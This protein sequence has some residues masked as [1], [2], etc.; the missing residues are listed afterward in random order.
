VFNLGGTSSSWLSQKQVW[1]WLYA[2][3]W[4]VIWHHHQFETM[5]HFWSLA[6]EEHFYLVW[7]WVI[8][9]SS[10]KT[11]IRICIACFC[12]SV[13]SR[14]LLVMWGVSKES[15]WHLDTSH[16]DSL[17]LGGWLA[18]TVRGPAGSAPLVGQAKKLAA[19]AFLA[20]ASVIFWRRGMSH[21]DSMFQIFGFPPLVLFFG[22]GLVLVV[23]ASPSSLVGMIF[24]SW[25]MRFFGKYSYGIYVWHWLLSGRFHSLFPTKHY[26]ARFGEFIPAVALHAFLSSVTSIIIAILSFHM[27]ELFFIKLKRFFASSWQGW[28]TRRVGGL[29]GT[30][31]PELRLR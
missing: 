6:V 23:H 21:M 5:E 15:I 29:R 18:L 9:F 22:A 14:T 3:N 24:N 28:P 20:L 8:W 31:S 10:R 30:A 7:P 13:L 1:A 25:L 19:L 4:G 12:A 26:L 17:C 2:V 27:Y 16:L 11:A